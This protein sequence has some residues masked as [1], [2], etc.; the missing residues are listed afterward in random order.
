MGRVTARYLAERGYR[1]YATSRNPKGLQADFEAMGVSHPPRVLAMDL[2]SKSSVTQA[3]GTILEEAGGIDVLVNNAGYGLVSTVEEAEEEEIMEQFEINLFGLLRVTREVIPIMR[4]RQ[5]GVIINI[6]SFL[7]RVGLPLLTF[8]NAS[9]YAVEGVTDSLRFELAPAGIRVHSVMPGF[10]ST[11][12]A[13]KNLK[14]NAMIQS[15]QSPY[16]P[17]SRR[18][19]PRIVQEINRGDDPLEVARAIHTLIEDPKSPARIPVGEVAKKFLAMRRE[20]SDAE[21]EQ[22]VR[23]NYEF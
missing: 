14:V 7:G 3:V 17:L 10:F 5:S 19:T 8:Y 11:Q 12:F 16:A 15:E 22:R 1:V 2:H 13:R 18:L 20:L 23:D 6:S 9:K 21:Y 4:R